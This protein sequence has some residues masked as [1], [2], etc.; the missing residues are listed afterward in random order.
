MKPELILHRI[1]SE[2]REMPGLRLTPSQVRRLWN[3]DATTCATALARLLEEHFLSRTHDGS[4]VLFP[5]TRVCGR[6][7][8]RRRGAPAPNRVP[9]IGVAVGEPSPLDT[10]CAAAH[11]GHHDHAHRRCTRDDHG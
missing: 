11:G 1:R 4:Y 7:S 5:G 6:R 3:L 8:R 10:V 2:Y 9:A